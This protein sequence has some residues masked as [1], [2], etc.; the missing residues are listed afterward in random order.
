MLIPMDS[1]QDTPVMETCFA[2]SRFWFYVTI[3]PCC[4]YFKPRLFCRR[5]WYENERPHS[6][7]AFVSRLYQR[8]FQPTIFKA[9]IRRE[10][11]KNLVNDL[12]H[13]VRRKDEVAEII[14]LRQFP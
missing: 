6:R 10:N 1:A 5:S 4:T 11:V 14:A 13:I 8:T 2:N 3:R 12:K 7:A 9:L